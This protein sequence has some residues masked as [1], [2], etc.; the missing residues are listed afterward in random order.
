[1]TRCCPV[2]R[3]CL[4]KQ[5]EPFDPG[6]VG[7][8]TTALFRIAIL[9]DEVAFPPEGLPNHEPPAPETIQ[10]GTEQ[11]LALR[12]NLLTSTVRSLENQSSMGSVTQ[13]SQLAL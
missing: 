3:S 2:D 13:L 9:N 5:L 12:V 6:L 4:P 1:M 10:A 7:I 8:P 11:P